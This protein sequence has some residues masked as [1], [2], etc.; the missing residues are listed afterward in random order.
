VTVVSGR[1][2]DRSDAGGSPLPI[3][4]RWWALDAVVGWVAAQYVGALAFTFVLTAFATE[5]FGLGVGAA[6]ALSGQL[7]RLSA[8]AP[9][10][11]MALWMIPVWAVQL[12]AVE[13]ATRLRGLSLRRDLG[14]R[15]RPNDLLWG[16]LAGLGAQLAVGIAYR[17]TDIDAGGPAQ[18]LTAKG[19]GLWGLVGLLVLL[20][21][22]APVVEELLFR[23]LLLR[24]L[25]VRLGARAALVVSS[26]VFA[27]VHLQVVQFPG[28]LVAGLVF[29]WLVQRSGRLGP[30]IVAHVAFNAATV[31]VMWFIG[32]G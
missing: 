22:A 14:L 19:Q 1:L 21:V 28:L 25:E 16:V 3:Q 4:A 11:A 20:A 32:T 31:L 7:L 13:L 6:G 23:G 29:G 10:V 9:L 17:L 18:Q 8:G 30:A 27:A 2:A 24:G 12:G 15:F 26:L 5:G